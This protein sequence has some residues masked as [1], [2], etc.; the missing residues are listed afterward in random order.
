VTVDYSGSPLRAAPSRSRGGPAVGGPAEAGSEGFALLTPEALGPILAEG[1]ARWSRVGAN[2][3]V[4]AGASFQI[5]D[6]PGDVLAV[7]LFEQDVV[8]IDRDAAGFG[9]FV[10]ATPRTD[11][12]FALQ[13]APTEFWALAGSR[14]LGRVDLLTAVMHEMGHLLGLDHA[15][16]G[17]HS[18]MEDTLAPG[19][20]RVPSWYDLAW[21][22]ESRR[23]P[24]SPTEAFFSGYGQE[25]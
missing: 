14:A 24:N 6:L 1:S 8:L 25:P 21:G 12:E 13:V 22:I 4:L 7:A 17:S 23:G 18:V 20:R 3:S 10:D 11:T 5:A 16:E 2:V 9:W 15:P 19:V